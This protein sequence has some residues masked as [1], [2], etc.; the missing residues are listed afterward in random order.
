MLDDTPHSIALGTAI[1]V[2][3]AMT[4]T[5]GLQMAMVGCVA[6][7]AKPLFRFNIVAGLLAVYISNPL[8]MVPLYWFNYLVGTLFVKGNIRYDDLVRLLQYEGFSQWWASLC[9]LFVEIGAPLLIGSLIVAL[10]SGVLSYPFVR[11]MLRVVRDERPGAV[12]VASQSP[13]QAPSC[14]E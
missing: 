11:W 5:I 14:S 7:L 2:F 9:K 8:T 6:V 4:P 13:E 12:P 3:V 10:V 1:G